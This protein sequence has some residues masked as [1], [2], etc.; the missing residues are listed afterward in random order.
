MLKIVIAETQ[1]ESRWILEGQLVGPWV[2]ELRRCWKAKH[3][4]ESSKR[5]AVDLNDVT[6]IDKSGERLLRAMSKTGADL[7]SNGIYTKHLLEK[8]KTRKSSLPRMLLC[9]AWG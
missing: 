1:T 4:G 9:C 5:C 8:L 3:T 7:I 2:I 6:L